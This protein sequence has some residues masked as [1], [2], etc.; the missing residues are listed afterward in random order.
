MKIQVDH[1]DHGPPP[2]LYKNPSKFPYFLGCR[3]PSDFICWRH[4]GFAEATEKICAFEVLQFN[5]CI[6]L[7]Q[8]E[9]ICGLK[10]ETN[11]KQTYVII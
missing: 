5:D 6:N 8:D 10:L 7:S 11:H 1:L 4:R 2:L 3:L 9:L